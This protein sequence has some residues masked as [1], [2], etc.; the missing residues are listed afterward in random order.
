VIRL[1]LALHSGQALFDTV[2]TVV[3][4]ALVIRVAHEALE[5]MRLPARDRNLVGQ[6]FA[7]PAHP[8]TLKAFPSLEEEP[9]KLLS[10]VIPACSD[11]GT[12]GWM[13]GAVPKIVSTLQARAE[14]LPSSFSYEV[15]LVVCLT[16]RDLYN[17]ALRQVEAYGVDRVRA[18][19]VT[20]PLPPGRALREGALR[21]RGQMVI[22][23]DQKGLDVFS[24]IDSFLV[25]LAR[26][27][28]QRNWQRPGEGGD[29]GVVWGGGRGGLS[30]L[31]PSRPFE[32][33][34]ARLLS[35]RNRGMSSPGQGQGSG[36]ATGEEV[37]LFQA[38]PK[39]VP[40]GRTDIG[41]DDVSPTNVQEHAH[42]RRGGRSLERCWLW[43]SDVSDVGV[44]LLFPSLSSL[45][46]RRWSA[47]MLPRHTIKAILGEQSLSTAAPD[48]LLFLAL[49]VCARAVLR[50]CC[51]RV[52]CP[53]LPRPVSWRLCIIRYLIPMSYPY[54]TELLLAIL[55]SSVS[56]REVPLEVTS[57]QRRR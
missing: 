22:L 28:Q 36:N 48:H 44:A 12:A 11:A 47:V 18:L 25:S 27:Q 49:D 55:S 14:S 21:A 56:M 38:V 43:M 16:S 7:D 32:S 41:G 46:R 9:R 19:C 45:A 57:V 17:I 33:P 15:I 53:P 51:C 30:P 31:S 40:V 23:L 3:L 5:L 4:L 54:Q 50:V 10:V 2:T 6:G 37:V 8:G 42:N 24:Q 29:F 52:R 39:D 34:N 1:S 35:P 13:Q 26:E 20:R